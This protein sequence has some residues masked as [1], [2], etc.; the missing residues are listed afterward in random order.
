MIKRCLGC[1]STMVTL[2]G[3]ALPDLI[4]LR[5]VSLIRF[6]APRTASKI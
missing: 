6:Q 5:L 4:Y 2:T 1:L 3:I